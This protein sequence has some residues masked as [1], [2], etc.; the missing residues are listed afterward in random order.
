MQIKRKRLIQL[1][2]FF[3]EFAFIEIYFVNDGVIS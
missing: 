2:I 1:Q 3:G